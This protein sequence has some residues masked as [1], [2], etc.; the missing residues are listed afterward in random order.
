MLIDIFNLLNAELRI[1]S[2]A[3]LILDAAIASLTEELGRANEL[4]KIGGGRS[5]FFSLK[6]D[7]CNV[8]S[9]FARMVLFDF[10]AFS[11]TLCLY[12]KHYL[13]IN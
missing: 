4:L 9:L 10:I 13:F 12:S 3:F 8:R 6:F 2:K 5:K 7:N 1:Q 11:E